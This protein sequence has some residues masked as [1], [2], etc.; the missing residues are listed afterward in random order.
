MRL[1]VP[2]E[3]TAGDAPGTVRNSS[4]GEYFELTAEAFRLL[5][6]FRGR[7]ASITDVVART[8]A[9]RSDGTAIRNFIRELQQ[10]GLLADSRTL[11]RPASPVNQRIANVSR[12]TMT[13]FNCPSRQLDE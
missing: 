1:K 9:T 12:S 2:L 4:S 6:Y 3:I 10:C 13:F 11:D 8:S 7:G 5:S